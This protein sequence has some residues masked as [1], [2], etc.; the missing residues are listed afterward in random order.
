MVARQR[1]GRH[2]SKK[3]PRPALQNAPRSARG[4]PSTPPCYL[5]PGNPLTRLGQR[6]S[7]ITHHASRE[8]RTT[9]NTVKE[10]A[11]TV[12]PTPC[13]TRIGSTARRGNQAPNDG[14]PPFI[15]ET[16]VPVQSQHLPVSWSMEQKP[17]RNITQ[18]SGPE[19]GWFSESSTHSCY[20]SPKP[21]SPSTP[22]RIGSNWTPYSP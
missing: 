1:M 16:R 10:G 18:R 11:E 14:A 13:R 9:R 4:T 15:L 2:A 5:L 22:S 17:Q 19:V 3:N 20:V 21:P 7:H 8:A 6:M 12:G